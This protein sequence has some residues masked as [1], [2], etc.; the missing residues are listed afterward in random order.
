LTAP[1]C[2]RIEELPIGL[3]KLA[4]R[5][6]L[7]LSPL[8]FDTEIQRLLRVLERV[9]GEAQ[10]QADED[11]EQTANRSRQH[12]PRA[13]QTAANRSPIAA[14]IPGPHVS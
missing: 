1:G 5:Q 2:P 4:H 11:A 8:R 7:E 12:E 3:A 14:E 13:I 9:I 6:A 10:E